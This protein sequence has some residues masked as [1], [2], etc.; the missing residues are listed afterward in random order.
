MEA[1][2]EGTIVAAKFTCTTLCSVT[3]SFTT[4]VEHHHISD[5][6]VQHT[7]CAAGHD[8]I[9]IVNLEAGF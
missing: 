3:A 9:V 5:I 8:A 2:H 1:G 7:V 6:S 4:W